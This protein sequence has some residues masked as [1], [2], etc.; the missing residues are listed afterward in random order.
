MSHRG[1]LLRGIGAAGLSG[2][3]TAVYAPAIEQD[4]L[5]TTS[6]DVAPPGWNAGRLSVVA[7][8]NVHAGGPNMAVELFPSRRANLSSN[9]RPRYIF[10]Q[11]GRPTGAH[12]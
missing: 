11:R 4:R 1:F 8:A 2:T 10:K 3:S 6:Y 5:V 7:I 9:G 12:P